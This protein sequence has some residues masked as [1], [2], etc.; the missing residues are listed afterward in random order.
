MKVS[1]HQ[2]LSFIAF[3]A[4]LLVVGVDYWWFRALLFENTAATLVVATSAASTA[5]SDLNA[6]AHTSTIAVSVAVARP[7]SKRDW[8]K[9]LSDKY[10]DVFESKIRFDLVDV[11]TPRRLVDAGDDD[12]TF[13]AQHAPRGFEQLLQRWKQMRAEEAARKQ[14]LA[15]FRAQRPADE[16]ESDDVDDPAE[17]EAQ[18]DEWDDRV[19]DHDDWDSLSKEQRRAARRA[20]KARRQT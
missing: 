15:A 9:Y 17:F 8:K 19:A 5:A 6:L 10:R 7:M 14:Q 16:S 13:H 4:L 3:G 20:A 18:T 1:R 12:A 2:R 11:Y